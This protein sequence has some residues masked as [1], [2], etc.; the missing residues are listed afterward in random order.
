MTEDLNDNRE[1]GHIM[2]RFVYTWSCM[3]VIVL[4]VALSGAL[5]RGEM[6]SAIQMGY[7][8][9]NS[10]SKV[11]GFGGN[12]GTSVSDLSLANSI[13]YGLKFG[14]YLE[15]VKWLG[16]ETEVFSSIPHIK[17][18]SATVTTASGTT[19]GDVPGASLRVINI[20]PFTLVV[21]YQR[22]RL[23]PYAGV[24]LGIFMATLRDTATGTGTSNSTIGLNTQLGLRYFVDENVSLFG[25][26]KYTRAHFNFAS[27]TAVPAQSSGGGYKGDYANN[28]VA[29]GVAYHFN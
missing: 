13:E 15:S 5:A 7:S 9:P 27:F 1:S 17:Q 6:Y 28:I 21:R 18:Q 24:G 14:Y 20:S 12:Q 4:S 11:T 26:W 16:L 23:E 29:F 8:M 25:E 10:F 2:R 3:A 22:G 19:T